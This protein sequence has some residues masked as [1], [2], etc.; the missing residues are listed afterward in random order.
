M[1]SAVP[2]QSGL[3]PEPER[4][5]ALTDAVTRLRRSL[6]RAIRP[7]YPWETLPMAQVEVLQLLDER[8]DLAVGEVAATLRLAPNTVSTLVGQLL[9]DGLVERRSDH[10][11]RRIGRL[12]LSEDGRHRLGGW[13]HAHELLI[14]D[15]VRGLPAADRDRLLEAVHAIEALGFALLDGPD[16]EPGAPRG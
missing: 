1:V 7:E 13:Q 11:D 9:R 16:P 2:D 12:S 4:L 15:A 6:R 3:D 14:T 8:P 5:R 10:H